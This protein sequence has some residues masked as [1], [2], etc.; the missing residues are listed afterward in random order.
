[1]IFMDKAILIVDDDAHAREILQR[2]LKKHFA[3][4]VVDC[5]ESAVRVLQSAPIDVIM[6]DLVMP[7]QDGLV[8]VDIVSRDF[9][10]I[11]IIVISGNATFSKVVEAMQ[12]GAADFIEKPIVDPN[13]LKVVIDKTLDLYETK[14]EVRRLKQLLYPDFDM[15][16]VIA[17]SHAMQNVIKKV[18]RISAVDTT[19]LITGETGVGKDMIATLIASNSE[20]KNN[21]F[22]AVNCGSIPE[23]LLESMLFGHKKGSFTGAIRD[24]IGFFEEANGGT[25]FLDE[26]SETTLAF[27]TKLLRVLENRTIRKVGD[28]YDINI[29]VRILTATNKDL[30]S[31]VQKKRFREDLYYRLNVIEIYIPPLRER[32]EDIELLADHFIKDFAEKYKKPLYSISKETIDILLRHH[33]KGNIRELKNVIEHAVVMA[34]HDTLLPIDLPAYIC[35]DDSADKQHIALALDICAKHTTDS[36]LRGGGTRGGRGVDVNGKCYDRQSSDDAPSQPDENMPVYESYHD[37][38][39]TAKSTF[40]HIYLTQLIQRAD[41]C[42]TKAA[43]LSGISLS[44]LYKKMKMYKITIKNS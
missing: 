3:V 42:M 39:A 18:K 14:Q 35:A 8:L 19:V 26:I 31:E 5:V 17:Q 9:P 7:R 36:T 41:G 23:T 11:P 16:D 1:M 44:F 34:T 30:A 40:E 33:W 24:Q 21:R 38:Y 28:K 29:N 4:T 37:D 43:K 32:V 27:Q 6:T 13:I 20:R 22:V 10:Q 12:K 25:I 15:G 2:H